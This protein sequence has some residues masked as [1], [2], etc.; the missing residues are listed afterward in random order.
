MKQNIWCPLFIM[1]EVKDVRNMSDRKRKYRRFLWYILIAVILGEAALVLGTVR[2][3]L[4]A[5][6]VDVSAIESISVYAG[7]EPVGIYME[8]QGV[9]V[10]DC[11]ELKDSNGQIV[12]PAEHIIRPG[13]Y[14]QR[15][16]GTELTSKQ[17]L[18]ELVAENQ[19]ETMELEVLRRDELIDLALTPV[20]TEDGSYKLGIWV[21]DNIQGIGTLT[22]VTTNGN[23]VA[24][25]HGISDIDT[26]IRLEISRGDLYKASILSVQKGEPGSPGELRGVIDYEKKNLLGTITAN[27]GNGIQGQLDISEL[28]ADEQPLYELGFKQEIVTGDAAIRCDVGDGIKEYT[29]SITDIDMN[30]NDSNKSFTIEVTDPDLIAATGGIVQGMSGSPIIQN[31]KLIGAVTHVF[32]ND[33]TRGYGIFIENM[34]AQ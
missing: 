2:Q 21:R 6:T 26:G 13:D 23:F 33:P 3:P 27:T 31:G 16:N 9:L 5:E 12:Y 34:L 30:A 7:G 22:C 28:N 25:G 11:G 10:V 14:I 20:L 24:L 1:K 15:V 8:T 17:Q 29:I 32:V 4:K 18:A 19:G